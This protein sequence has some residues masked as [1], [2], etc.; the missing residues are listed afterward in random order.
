MSSSESDKSGT[1]RQSPPSSEDMKNSGGS[2]VIKL[3]TYSIVKYLSSNLPTTFTGMIY[4]K[5]LQ[6]LYYG[7][8]AIRQI[9]RKTYFEKYHQY[10]DNLLKK[11][12]STIRL[13]VL[14]DDPDIALGFSVSREDVLDYIYVN[15]ECRRTGI[16]KC[17]MP[18]NITTFTHLTKWMNP[19]WPNNPKYRHLVFNPF[20]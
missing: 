3:P 1:E 5:W 20:I 15:V 9:P 2:G 8:K 17:L 4:S 19:M 12:D 10:I 14:S 13:A 11:P 18:G 6:S 16:A 7:N